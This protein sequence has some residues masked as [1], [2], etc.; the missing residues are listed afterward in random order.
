MAHQKNPLDKII[1]LY[2]TMS[3]KDLAKKMN[4][5]ISYVRNVGGRYGLKKKARYWSEKDKKTLLKH[6]KD[7]LV[8][9]MEKLPKRSKW[10][11]IN[12]YRELK[13]KR[14]K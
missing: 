10:A 12:K 7:G 9:V 2:P 14:K 11:I 8:I 3:D 6:Y 13:G 4:V 5:K 1:M